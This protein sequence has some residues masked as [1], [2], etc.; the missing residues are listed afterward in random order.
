MSV[1]F[2][3]VVSSAFSSV[4]NGSVLGM[5]MG[6][7]GAGTG[8][9]AGAGIGC[10]WMGEPPGVDPSSSCS[11]RFWSRAKRKK[12]TQALKKKIPLIQFN[13]ITL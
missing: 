3:V 4:R 5:G 13:T 7:E 8:P 2:K 6:P 12:Y 10:D 11:K 1:D 9:G